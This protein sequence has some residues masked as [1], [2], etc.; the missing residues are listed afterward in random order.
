MLLFKTFIFVE[1]VDPRIF[2]LIQLAGTG[3]GAE[4]NP[5]SGSCVSWQARA[6]NYLKNR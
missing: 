1:K 5:D 4:R 3:I 2:L 6:V